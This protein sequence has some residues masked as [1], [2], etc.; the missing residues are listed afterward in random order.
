MIPP[1][2][3]VDDEPFIRRALTFVLTREGYAVIPAAGGREAIERIQ[4]LHPRLIFLDVMMPEMDGYEVCR[5]IKRDPATRET[6]IILLTARGEE[7]DHG[8]G[9]AVGADEYMTKPFSPSRVLARV[10]D[11]VGWPEEVPASGS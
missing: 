9:L 2:L 8:T 10:R 1:I 11:I 4:T 6:Y 3:V 5:E 7:I